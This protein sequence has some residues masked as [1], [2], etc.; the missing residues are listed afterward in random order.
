MRVAKPEPGDPETAERIWGEA[1]S[2]LTPARDLAEKDAGLQE[3]VNKYRDQLDRL[4]KEQ[5]AQE[6]QSGGEQQA[7]EQPKRK[8]QR[9]KRDQNPRNDAPETADRTDDGERKE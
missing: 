2:Y 1:E 8:Q 5:R 9:T 7:Q 3:L 4:R 6:A